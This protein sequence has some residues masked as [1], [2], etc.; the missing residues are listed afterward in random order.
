MLVD[1]E[2]KAVAILQSNY[3][4]WKGYF[5]IISAADEFLIFDNVQFT[6]RDWRNRNK[7][8]NGGKLMWLTIPVI[9]KGAYEAS[10]NTIPIADKSWAR[11][12]WRSIQ[13]AYGKAPHFR[14]LAPRLEATYD[15]ASDLTLL[16][17]V[18]EL[19]LRTLSDALGLQTHF[20]RT[21]TI[22]RQAEDQTGRLLELCIA[23]N[24]T[25]YI[26][27]PAAKS[28]IEQ[29]QFDDENIA[30]AYANYAGYPIYDQGLEPFE[31]G[32]SVLDLLFRFGE[33]ARQYL[34]TVNGSS[35][36]LDICR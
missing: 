12:H 24:A 34:K 23:R 8:V 29:K 3:I 27:G 28:Y 9:S 13:H 4:P 17:E 35:S 22:P 15:Q 20:L 2:S 21:E 32:V 5:D 14:W 30:L 18:N 1:R 26:S 11:K 33:E 7:I 6:R 10:I 36:F 19:F 16:S 31:H 25:T